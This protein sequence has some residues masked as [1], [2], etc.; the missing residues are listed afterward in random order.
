MELVVKALA[1]AVVVVIIQLLSRTKNAYIAGLIP[2][3]PTFA[4]IAH[5]VVGTQRTMSDLKETI[6]FGMFSLIPY[7]AYLVTLYF[8]VD[9]FRLL[10]SLLG[11]T[12]CWIVAATVLIVV[13]GR[14]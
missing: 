5:Y 11:A 1:G 8:L 6:L 2:L 9:R 10:A 12:L 4:L 14:M 3:F 7:F 13:W